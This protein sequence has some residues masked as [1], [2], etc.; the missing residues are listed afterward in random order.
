M[1]CIFCHKDS[2][3]SVS[4]EHIIPES[5]GND[6]FILNKGV[7][8]DSCNNK[9]STKFEQQ[10]LNIPFFKQTRH[11]LNIVSKK[12]KIPSDRGFMIHPDA[13]VDFHKHK[14]K[15]E[16]IDVPDVEAKKKLKNRKKVEVF[17]VTFGP[18]GEGNIFLS[19]FL[20]KIAIEN[21]AFYAQNNGIPVNG[22]L[23]QD[24]LTLMKNYVRKSQ[25]NEYWPYKCRIL[26]H[27]EAGFINQKSGE[28]QTI[29]TTIRFI[30]TKENALF[31]QF[32]FMGVEYT[33]DVLN[34]ST[35][36]IEKWLSENNN[37]SPV[38]EG[39]LESLA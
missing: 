36:L 5:L 7:V 32:L 15:G 20:G 37:R 1:T 2:S 6:C 38:F 13:A 39:A 10:L 31:H 14:R 35:E 34:P 28:C 11:K 22:Y 25:K 24:C 17:T 16:S 4:E 27:Q 9:F 30:H 21:L 33:I 12:G 26:F 29:V 23:A 3:S 8:C 18:V 19:K